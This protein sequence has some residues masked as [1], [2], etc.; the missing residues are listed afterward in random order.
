MTG[1]E[2]SGRACNGDT[3][4]YFSASG[5]SAN[6]AIL[7][8]NGLGSQLINFLPGWVT[9]FSEAGFY[10]I[11]MDN[12]DVGMSTKTLGDVPDLQDLIDRW[13]KDRIASGFTAAYDLADMALDCVAVLDALEIDRAHVWGMSMGGMIAQTLAINHAERLLSMTS[14]MSTTGDPGVGRSTPESAAQLVAAGNDRA[15]I[16]KSAVAA[17][18]LHSGS[19][20]QESWARSLE[21]AAYDRCYHPQGK[22]WQLLAI[23]ASGSRA[24][25]LPEVAI[26]SMIIHGRLDSLVHL[27]GGEATAALIPDADLVIHDQMGHDIPEPLWNEYLA[28]FQRLVDRAK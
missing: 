8:V 10:V 24:D 25:Q 13:F 16:I 26:P 6:P 21:E 28:D 5:D 12:R 18:R 23:L 27:D 1:I 4:L 2:H 15:S 20:Y 19:L 17:R 9:K 3:E 14:V 7:F 11:R 22:T